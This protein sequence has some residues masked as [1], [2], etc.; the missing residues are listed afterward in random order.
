MSIPSLPR[1]VN[2][3]V[4]ESSPVALSV[5]LYVLPTGGAS[6]GVVVVTVLKLGGKCDY[7]F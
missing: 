5:Y 7:Q 2:R 4:T 6:I 3:T 1:L